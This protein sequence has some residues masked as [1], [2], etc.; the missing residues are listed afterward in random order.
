MRNV[1]ASGD[2]CF[3]WI[4]GCRLHSRC[5]FYLLLEHLY[6]SS[7]NTESGILHKP[8]RTTASWNKSRQQQ[9]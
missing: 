5:H 4:R 3:E 2:C 1:L 9:S 6:P 7:V 8:A